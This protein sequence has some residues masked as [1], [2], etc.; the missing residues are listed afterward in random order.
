MTDSPADRVEQ[1]RRDIRR[2]DRLYYVQAAPEIDDRRY[3]AMFAEL[4]RLEREHPELVTPD[5]PT[6]RVGGE[7]IDGFRT[8]EHAVAMLS[9]DNT[10]SRD[11][12]AEFDRRVREAL[13]ADGADRFHYLCEPKI[14]GVAVTLRYERGALVL[15]ASRGDGRRGDDVTHNV[16]TIHA[17]PLRLATDEPPEVLEVRGEVY[18]PRRDFAAH[19]AARAERGEEPFANPRNAAAGT[20]KQLDPA[21]AAARG[22][23]FVAHGLGEV[24][25]DVG[26]R[27]SDAYD[28]LA[29]WG[30]PVSGHRRLCETLEEVREA[31]DDWLARRNEADYET[32]G[33]VVKVD[34]LTLRDVLGQTSRYPRWCIAYK[35]D[36]QRAWTTLRAVDFQVGRL[37]T[38]TPVARFDEVHLAG[39]RVTNASLHNFDQVERLDV[40][41]GDTIAVEKAGEIIPQV[42]AVDFKKRPADARPVAPPATCPDCG[43]PTRRD[44]GGVYLRCVNPACPAQ[45][46]QRLRFFAARGQM[47]I[48]TLGPAVIDQLVERGLVRSV[49]D[50]YRLRP[51]DLADLERMGEKSAANLVEAIDASKGRGLSRVLAGLGIRHVGGRAAEV[52]AE[53]YP[54]VDALLAAPVEELVSIHEIGPAI[55]ESLASFLASE[56]GR[57]TIEDLRAAGVEMTSDRFV[58]GGSGE[59]DRPLAGKTV[60]VTGTLAGFSRAEATEAVQAAGGRVASSVSKRTDFVVAGESAGSKLAKARSLGVEVIDE[61]EFRRR[62]GL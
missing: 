37:G 44:A 32:D 10:Y 45:L 56:A 47:D 21:V 62:L 16:R 4:E 55:A 6:Q 52:L 51:G 22:L 8:V 59:T 19:N 53:Q 39:T 35:Y 26:A 11:E 43:E 20:L 38:I 54:D 12:L 46:R 49:G 1:L 29:R 27:A 58:G 28:R 24:V 5:S 13:A 60:V 23:S 41:A 33:M 15:A 17:V 14:D 7:P 3:D 48:D 25:G 50:L 30:V 40:R 18:W 9:I 57:R 61:T 31:I 34:E 36:P 42:V 2:H